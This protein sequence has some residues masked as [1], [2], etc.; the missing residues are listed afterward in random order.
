MGLSVRKKKPPD[1]NRDDMMETEVRMRNEARKKVKSRWEKKPP[2]ILRVHIARGAYARTNV[3]SADRSRKDVLNEVTKTTSW[4]LLRTSSLFY[5]TLVF[6]P[7]SNFAWE[8]LSGLRHLEEKKDKMH[9][10]MI[11]EMEETS[12]ISE[13]SAVHEETSR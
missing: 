10:E 4:N 12:I 13:M 8:M 2:D 6:K 9:R 7:I 3:G 5:S 11:E 1:K